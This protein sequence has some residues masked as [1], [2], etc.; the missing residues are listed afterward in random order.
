MPGRKVRKST[1]IVK[2]R[3][4]EDV[5][6]AE[7]LAGSEEELAEELTSDT[8]RVGQKMSDLD[9]VLREIREFRR[10]TVESLNAIREDIR[11]ANCRIDVTEKRI[12]DTEERI[13]YMEEATC[14]LIQFCKKLKEKQVDQEGRA[15]R[16]N[17]RLHGIKEGAEKDAESGWGHH[18][19]AVH[20][21]SDPV[22]V[23][24][25]HF[26][27][28]QQNVP[29]PPCSAWNYEHWEGNKTRTSFD[30]LLASS[31]VAAFEK[32]ISSSIL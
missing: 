9:T 32:P 1:G 13:Q 21:H 26:Q 12:G 3:R 7:E 25:N 4:N 8:V 29:S 28:F 23:C 2:Q 20:L 16:D 22:E 17:V 27:L 5:G 18:V 10:E 11:K 30:S 14:E 15:R 6:L 19:A 24:H 31:F